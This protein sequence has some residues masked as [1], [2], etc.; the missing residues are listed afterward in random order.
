MILSL[1][2]DSSWETSQQVDWAMFLRRWTRMAIR[3]RRKEGSWAKGRAVTT[4]RTNNQPSSKTPAHTSDLAT[5]RTEL[6]ATTG[7][8]AVG[9]RLPR[10]KPLLGAVGT[11]G[12][13]SASWS[14]ATETLQYRIL[15]VCLAMLSSSVRASRL[16][17]PS[18]TLH[19]APPSCSPLP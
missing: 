3:N 8:T 10:Q 17:P 19:R 15:L 9:R 14:S 12:P 18:T 16:P 7:Q 2:N 4:R 5:E 1:A 6:V 11:K 13:T